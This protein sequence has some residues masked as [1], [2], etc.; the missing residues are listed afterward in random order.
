MN[1]NTIKRAAA[2]FTAAL[3]SISA[4][5]AAESPSFWAE[6]EVAAA[7]EAGIVPEEIQSGYTMPLSRADFTHLALSYLAK[8][9]GTKTIGADGSP[10]SDTDDRYVTDAYNRGII[11]GYGDGTFMPNNSITRQE[12]AKILINTQKAYLGKAPEA[13]GESPAYTDSDLISDWARD[14]VTL[15]SEMKIMQGME[16]GS[17]RPHDT[18]TTE[19]AII[20]FCRLYNSTVSQELKEPTADN[21][22]PPIRGMLKI[23]DGELNNGYETVTLNGVNLG[24]WLLVETWLSPI[25]DPN[26]VMA[27][28][29]IKS[30]LTNRF[31]QF[32]A[33]EVEE[34]YQTNFITENDFKTIAALGFNHVRIPFWYRNFLNE[35]GSFLRENPDEIQ[36]FKRLDFA[37]EMCEKYG[38]YAV[39]D[40]HGCPGGQSLN[41]STGTN[42]SNALYTNRK[43]QKMMEDLWVA[44]AARYKDNQCIAAYD[45]M[46]E[47][48]NNGSNNDPKGWKP[49]SPQAVSLTNSIYDTMIKAIRRVDPNHIITVEG[50]WSMNVLPDPT[51]YGWTNVMYQLHIYDDSEYMINQRI[52]ELRYAQKK[53]GVAVYI[54]EYNS[55]S[56]E[57]YAAGRYSDEKLNRAKWNYKGVCAGFDGWT[58]YNKNLDTKTDISS[59]SLE[60]LTKL[61]GEDM[62]TENGF[63]FDTRE[64]NKIAN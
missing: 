63:Y 7:I 22:K 40:M 52:D 37:L 59:A 19:Q 41:H 10:F 5:Y 38:L 28:A 8:L 34:L 62:L 29:D 18:Y 13:S 23:V 3:L 1:F 48:H 64:Y 27:N 14:F 54:G 61:L 57:R 17:F 50:I 11:G 42:G 56:R 55:R 15:A 16:D 24:N 26:E 35:D 4:V 39:L 53:Y 6:E 45:I 36:G 44:I 30:I 58:L 31:G 49:E 33:D 20:T 21:V 60:S 43:Y 9:Q 47:P 25:Y 51:E 12:A 2:A 32:A 46:N